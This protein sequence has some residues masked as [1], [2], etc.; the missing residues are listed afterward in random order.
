MKNPKSN[1][2]GLRQVVCLFLTVFALR[3][4]IACGSES[5]DLKL[6]V[7][8]LTFGTKHHFFGYIGQCLTIPWNASGRYVLGLEIDK[9][10]RLPAP[11]EFATVILVDTYH[12]NK[13]I[14]L[15]PF[16]ISKCHFC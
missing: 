7:E 12:D 1:R 16:P 4:M 14:R 3:G 9:I 15:V 6:T 8:Q 13:I 2:W 5:A 11:E 10:D